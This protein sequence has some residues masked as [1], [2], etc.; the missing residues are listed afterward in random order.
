MM[1]LH[2][3]VLQHMNLLD[4]LLVRAPYEISMSQSF[5][6]VFIPSLDG[7]PCS[8]ADSHLSSFW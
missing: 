2:L 8:A 7:C 1:S 6:L 3:S 5:P 4:H